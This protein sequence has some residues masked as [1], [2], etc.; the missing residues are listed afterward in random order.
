MTESQPTLEQLHEQLTPEQI[1]HITELLK[2]P[3][4]AISQLPE[5]EQ[6][7]YREAQQSVV[8]A[9]RA[10]ERIAHEIWID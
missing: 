3:E 8:D 4:K 1:E 5:A 7:S 2:D 10:G 9:R 6:Q